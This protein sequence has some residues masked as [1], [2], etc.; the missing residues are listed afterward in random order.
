LGWRNKCGKVL[1]VIIVVEY[2]FRIG[3]WKS[4][5]IREKTPY[6]EGEG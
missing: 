3:G 5:M 4:K 2:Y 1:I 6:I